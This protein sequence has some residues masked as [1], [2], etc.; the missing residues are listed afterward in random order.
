MLVAGVLCATPVFADLTTN[1]QGYWQF[2][3]DGSDASGNGR[4]LTLQGG[5]G[6]TSGLLGQALSLPGNVNEYA[7][8]TVDDTAF[9]F[10]A[11][12]FT[13]QTWVDYTSTTNEQVLIEKFSGQTGP[14]WTLTKLSSNQYQFYA[15][16]I[17]GTNSSVLS[18]TTGVWHQVVAE[19][20]GNTLTI[21]FDDT[22]V[23]TNTG[24][25]VTITTSPNGLLVGKRDP[26]DGRGLA[27]DG[28]EDETAIWSRALSNTEIA[29][30]YNSGA[31][32]SI[33]PEPDTWLF[34][35]CGFVPMILMRR[36]KAPGRKPLLETNN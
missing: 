31:G 4:T 7:G 13:I 22:V 5:V 34:L 32:L 6:F 24:F 10:G 28:A 33:A 27:T 9:D 21:Y 1:L 23:A 16:P 18:I 35:A 3:G 12:D 25:N 14:G 29:S 36:K 8:R 17:G 26:A 19:R 15:D 11:G 30:L 2:N 20:S